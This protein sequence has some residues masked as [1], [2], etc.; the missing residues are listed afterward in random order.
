MHLKK[1]Y[2]NTMFKISIRVLNISFMSM[3]YQCWIKFWP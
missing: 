1:I 2:V 3:T